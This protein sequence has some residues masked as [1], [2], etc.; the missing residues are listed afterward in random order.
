MG[1][2]AREFHD[3]SPE[4]AVLAGFEVGLGNFANHPVI[5]SL[6]SIYRT[7]QGEVNGEQHGTFDKGQLVVK[8]KAGY[9]VA[10]ITVKAG[11]GIDGMSVTFMRIHNKT[12]DPSD[13]YTSEWIGGKGGG[14]ETL[15]A[16]TGTPVSGIFGKLNAKQE[17]NGL[18]LVFGGS[19]P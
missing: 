17:V 16:G 10:G 9:A 1:S 8:A 3:V 4:G 5:H 2:G 15:L 6:R 14:R 18:G 12:F 13:S 7:S 19:T 11:L